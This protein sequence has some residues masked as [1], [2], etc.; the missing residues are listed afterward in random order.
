MKLTQSKQ[1]GLSLELQRDNHMKQLLLIQERRKRAKRKER[2]K[3]QQNTD[4]D[5]AAHLQASHKP[6]AGDAEGQNP[7]PSQKHSPST[8]NH[9]P[10]IQGFF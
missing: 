3:A 10:E 4:K 1:A 5:A 2:L 7:L 8:E 9:L 6:F